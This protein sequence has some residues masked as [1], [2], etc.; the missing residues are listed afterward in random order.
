VATA[1]N[2][3]IDAHSEPKRSE[4]RELHC[5]MLALMPACKLWFLDGK[6]ENEKT[7]SNPSIGYGIQTM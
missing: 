3:H 7:V 2:Q 5:M 4:M 1:I 6:D